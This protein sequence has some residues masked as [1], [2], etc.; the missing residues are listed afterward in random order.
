M[1]AT[2]PGVGGV[3]ITV[4]RRL[5]SLYALDPEAPVT[6]FLVDD[7]QGGSRTLLA[8][9]GDELRL[10]VVLDGAVR[11]DLAQR[12]PRQR[13]DGTNLGA[14]CTLTE[15]VSHFLFL[16]FCAR[17]GRH[18]TQL[19]LE[20]QGEVDKYL[21]AAFLLSLQNEGAVSLRLR[22]LLFRDYRLR[23][24][25]HDESAD[26]YHE[27]SRLAFAWCGFLEAEYLRRDRLHDLRREARRFYRLGQRE[28]LLRIADVA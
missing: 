21:T 12:D 16:L 13:L 18:A 27:A 10:A 22:E 26:R 24:G 4:Q 2:A 5:E 19:E 23:D 1:G 20:L 11:T 6:E 7:A 14:L 8:Q 9:D 28:K 25:L 17:A 3:A 15:E